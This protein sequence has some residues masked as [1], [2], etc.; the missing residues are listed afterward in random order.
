MTAGLDRLQLFTAPRQLL[1][2]SLTLEHGRGVSN[3]VFGAPAPERLAEFTLD[4]R[5]FILQVIH[6][7]ESIC[8][9]HITM[10]SRSGCEGLSDHSNFA[11]PSRQW[12]AIKV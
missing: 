3:T 10:T 5:L 1:E 2:T 7:A 11:V 12:R 6:A 8:T 9:L 4:S